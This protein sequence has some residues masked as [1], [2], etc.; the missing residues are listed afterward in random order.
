MGCQLKGLG[1]ARGQWTAVE[2]EADV[3]CVPVHGRACDSHQ[4]NL[5]AGFQLLPGAGCAP[6]VIQ[7]VPYR[8]EL[9]QTISSAA[10]GYGFT[11]LSSKTK[12]IMKVWGMRLNKDSQ[13]RFH[14]IFSMGN[15]SY[16]QCGRKVDFDGQVVQVA[17]SQDHSLLLTDKEVYS[18]GRHTHKLGGELA[19]VNVV[20]VDTYG[21]CYLVVLAGGGL[22]RWG[23][24]EY[25]QLAS[26]TDSRQAVCGGTGCAVLNR[27]G[28][29]FVWG[30]GI[31][32]KGPNLLETALSEMI[33][34]TLFGLMEFNPGVQ[35]SYLCEARTSKGAWVEDQYFPWGVTIPGESVDV[36]CGVDHMVTLIKSLI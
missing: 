14:R 11:W 20:Q 23:N 2:A 30:Y 13:L 4:P 19:R 16:G 21:D 12:D 25:L 22:F 6:F 5:R 8:L 7:A 1:P 35:E 27:E 9:G 17:C 33:P 36:V 31:L 18:C 24:S 3:P 32:G 26:V 15:N 28:H 34:P 29:I 10:C